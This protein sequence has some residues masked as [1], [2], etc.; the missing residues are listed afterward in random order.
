MC[1]FILFFNRLSN[2]SWPVDRFQCLRVCFL[3]AIPRFFSMPHRGTVVHFHR[4]QLRFNTPI[5]CSYAAYNPHLW[6]PSKL[7]DSPIIDPFLTSLYMTFLYIN[8]GPRHL[9]SHPSKFYRHQKR[10]QKGVGGAP[11]PPIL[12]P[13]GGGGVRPPSPH[14][15]LF[16]GN[17]FGKKAALKFY[18]HG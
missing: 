12:P 15:P 5:V 13:Q 6:T 10:I 7:S 17:L 14:S 18:T 8:M 1:T 2:K 11:D 4:T 3:F 16:F 9:L